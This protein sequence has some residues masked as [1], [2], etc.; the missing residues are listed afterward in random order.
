MKVES[1]ANKRPGAGP[2][3]TIHTGDRFGRWTVVAQAESSSTGRKW[4]CRCECGRERKIRQEMLRMKSRSCGCLKAEKLSARMQVQARVHGEG[5]HHYGKETP[6]YRTWLGINARCFCPSNPAYKDYGGRG[7]TIC[8]EWHHSYLSF[9]S[10]VGRRPTPSHTI[11]RFPNN[12]GNYE[13]GNVRWATQTQQCRN[14]R[15]NRYLTAN[16]RTMILVEWAQL[17]GVCHST[18]INRIKSGWPVERA[19]TTPKL[20]QLDY[21]SKEV[22]RCA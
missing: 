20:M 19:L 4:L 1:H 18:I 8:D 12:N 22:R 14:K 11:D 6:E 17:L 7:I 5:N 10:Y 15:N 9:L 2:P 21:T 16:G 3:P 13:P